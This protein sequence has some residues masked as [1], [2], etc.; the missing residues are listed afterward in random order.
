MQ[1]HTGDEAR[2]AMVR[3]DVGQDTMLAVLGDIYHKSRFGDYMSLL[4]H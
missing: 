3:G 4:I 2:Q 1:L